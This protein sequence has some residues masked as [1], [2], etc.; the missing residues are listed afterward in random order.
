MKRNIPL[1]LALVGIGT[2]VGV[3]AARLETSSKNSMSQDAK[4]GCCSVASG[5]CCSE[6]AG[7]GASCC[8][9][10]A[11]PTASCCALPSTKELLS[12]SPSVAPAVQDE[13]K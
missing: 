3:A 10:S 1:T 13:S 11:G 8:S 5:S 2:L 4:A 7:T 6:S 9:E 12:E